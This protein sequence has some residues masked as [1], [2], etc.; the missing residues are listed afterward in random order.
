MHT[1]QDIHMTEM[2]T[3]H[4]IGEDVHYTVYNIYIYNGINYFVIKQAF[5][6]LTIK[7]QSR[8]HVQQHH[9]ATQ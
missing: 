6:I 9:Y 7:L 2:C 8:R 4:A 1:M 3:V 5:A